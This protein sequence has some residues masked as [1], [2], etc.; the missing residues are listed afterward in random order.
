MPG[1]RHRAEPAQSHR[2]HERNVRTDS[3]KTCY[4]TRVLSEFQRVWASFGAFSISFSAFW[5]GFERLFEA[6]S[7][8]RAHRRGCAAKTR[9]ASSSAHGARAARPCGEAMIADAKVGQCGSGGVMG[10]RRTPARRIG[11]S[12]HEPGSARAGWRARLSDRLPDPSSPPPVDRTSTCPTARPHVVR[13][14][15]PAT[16]IDV[17]VCFFHPPGHR[18][19]QDPCANPAHFHKRAATPFLHRP[20]FSECAPSAWGVPR[21]RRAKYLGLVNGN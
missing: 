18:L 5:V 16:V 17:L 20:N 11:W 15:R 9:D 13:A 8:S 4:R 2:P 3:R 1:P 21:V 14:F 10:V 19:R 6:R 7:A 12:S